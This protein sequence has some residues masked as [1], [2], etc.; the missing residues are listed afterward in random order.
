VEAACRKK[1]ADQFTAQ[2]E[3]QTEELTRDPRK[4]KKWIKEK[5]R[6]D[7]KLGS[8]VTIAGHYC[9]RKAVRDGSCKQHLWTHGLTSGGAK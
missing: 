8:H 3:R 9:T 5:H 1:V 2:A 7:D 4:C 6:W